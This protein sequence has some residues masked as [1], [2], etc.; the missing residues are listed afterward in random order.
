MC[1]VLATHE[2]RRVVVSDSLGVSESLKRGVRLD[3]LLLQRHFLPNENNNTH[4]LMTSHD[5]MWCDVRDV[6]LG[7]IF[8]FFL[9]LGGF[10]LQLSNHGE[11]TND[12]LRV[13]SL[14]GSRLA[15]VYTQNIP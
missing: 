14:S 9:L 12:L 15:T 2:S 3:Y 5:R 6:Y 13:L 11:V 10:L 1:E 4:K 7:A 8:L